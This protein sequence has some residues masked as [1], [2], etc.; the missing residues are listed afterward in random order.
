MGTLW[1]RYINLDITQGNNDNNEHYIREQHI[2]IIIMNTTSINNKNKKKKYHTT[3]WAFPNRTNFG[4]RGGRDFPHSPFKYYVVTQ[5][6][7]HQQ[8]LSH[9]NNYGELATLKQRQPLVR[10]WS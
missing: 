8:K 3:Y 10:P 2:I 6:Q 9:W 4:M 7:R 5:P 1:E